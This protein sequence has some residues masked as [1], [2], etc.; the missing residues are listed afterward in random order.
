M[1]DSEALRL[2]LLDDDGGGPPLLLWL[3]EARWPGV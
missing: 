1:E 2:L 3:L